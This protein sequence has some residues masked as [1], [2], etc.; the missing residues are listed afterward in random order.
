MSA[1]GEHKGLYVMGIMQLTNGHCTLI[2]G[3]GKGVLKS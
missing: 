2:F 3:E 1:E